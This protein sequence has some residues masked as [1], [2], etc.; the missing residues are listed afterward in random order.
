[1]K[2]YFTF[3]FLLKLIVAIILLQ[4]LYFK[5]TGAAESKF[6]FESIGME[7]WGRI[8]SGIVE[9]ISAVLILLPRTVWIGAFLALGT[10]TGAIFFHFIK[11]GIVIQDD[12]GLLFILA[13]TVFLFSLIILWN[14]KDRIPLINWQKR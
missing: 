4:T 8:G 11:L 10:V 9:L 12:G 7:P 2:K 6:I 3:V 13:C 5:F 14:E 1:M